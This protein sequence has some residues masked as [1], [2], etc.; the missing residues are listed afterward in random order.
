ML[1]S[2]PT[3]SPLG[4]FHAVRTRDGEALAHSGKS[5]FAMNT[6]KTSHGR[7][8]VVE[9][10]FADGFWM[11]AEHEDLEP[12]AGVRSGPQIAVDWATGQGPAGTRPK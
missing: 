8:P 12:R 4:C 7:A 1:R 2:L 6:I 10:Q 5:Y 9:I 3:G 11:L